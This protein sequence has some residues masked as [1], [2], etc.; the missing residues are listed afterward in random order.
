MLELLLL[1][2]NMQEAI[3]KISLEDLFYRLNTVQVDLPPLRNR[4]DDIHL[5]FRKFAMDFAEKYHMPS[6]RLTKCRKTYHDL[7]LARKHSSTQ[8]YYRTTVCRRRK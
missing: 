3:H 6:V 4:K 5:I 7:P 2:V 8:K 1:L